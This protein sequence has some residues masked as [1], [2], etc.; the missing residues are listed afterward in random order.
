MRFILYLYSN[1]IMITDV[2]ANAGVFVNLY[3]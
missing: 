3:Q 1:K 2:I